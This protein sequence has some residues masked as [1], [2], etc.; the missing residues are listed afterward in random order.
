MNET[1]LGIRSL[2]RQCILYTFK[3]LDFELAG[4]RVLD[5]LPNELKFQLPSPGP[6][7]KW[8]QDSARVHFREPVSLLDFFIED[9]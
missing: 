3:V 9:S 1:A 6:R 8:R 5:A 4:H 7:D 2:V